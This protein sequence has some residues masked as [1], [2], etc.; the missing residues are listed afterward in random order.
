MTSLHGESVAKP[1]LEADFT[2]A[3]LD[4][5]L[6]IRL[7]YLEKLDERLDCLDTHLLKTGGQSTYHTSMDP[8]QLKHRD[9]V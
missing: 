3:E 6:Y 2:R 4:L 5:P 1:S 8:S 9:S 7:Q